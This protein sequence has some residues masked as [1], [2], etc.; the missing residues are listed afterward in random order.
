MCSQFFFKLI[1]FIL[2]G[3]FFCA[4]MCLTFKL[5]ENDDWL[6]SNFQDKKMFNHVLENRENHCKSTIK[7]N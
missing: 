2:I 7:S 5:L 6:F 4:Q 1:V 3:D